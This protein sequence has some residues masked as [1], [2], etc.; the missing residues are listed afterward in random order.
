MSQ[1]LGIIEDLDS[2]DQAVVETLWNEQRLLALENLSQ[3]QETTA[4]ALTDYVLL[5]AVRLTG[6]AA[7]FL[8]FVN[9]N[10]T[11]LNFHSWFD[12]VYKEHRLVNKTSQSSQ[13][14]LE[15]LG[16][17]GEPVRQRRPIITNNCQAED[18]FISGLPEW[19]I[20]QKR[21]LGVPLFSKGRVVAVVG[22]ANKAVDYASQDVHFLSLLMESMWRLIEKKQ[23]EAQLRQAHKL[24]SIG[25]L[26]SGIAHD[27][28]NILSC[29][30][31]YS[32]LA[33]QKA[34][35]NPELMDYLKEICDASS[36]AS[37]LVK[38]ILSFSRRQDQEYKTVD[39]KE[40]VSESLKLL[41]A[42]IPST[43]EIRPHLSNIE[44]QLMGDGSQL[45][46]IVINLCTNAAY[47]MREK[48]GMLDV[49]LEL[50]APDA[51]ILSKHEFLRQ[52]LC[53]KLV[54]QDTG[55]GISS[56]DLPH[57][58]EPFFTTKPKG[59]GTGLGLSMVQTIIERHHG[60]ITV[61]S[62]LNRGT[63]FCLYFPRLNFESPAALSQPVFK[64]SISNWRI[65][66]VDD[67]TP[68]IK[69]VEKMLEHMKH[70]AIVFSTG[71]DALEFLQQDPNAV[72]LLLTDHTMPKM[73]GLELAT[74]ARKLRPDLPVILMTGYGA[75]IHEEHR[76]LEGIHYVL[77][78]PFTVRSLTDA[79]QICKTVVSQAQGKTMETRL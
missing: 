60:C 67:E 70:R 16:L 7:G 33:I 55:S 51:S 29:I 42:S 37:D 47:A 5:E 52:G 28:N 17:W 45:Q 20:L 49:S 12:P 24:E 40:V 58:F 76:H 46:Q 36:R 14:L 21:H 56:E 18:Q 78:K 66:V 30:T 74:A 35:E 4:Q 71:V 34:S 63:R 13:Y 75:E 65:L 44:S 32:E 54:I 48:G 3:M 6:S 61:T 9:E 69:L 59:E 64:A 38:Q 11:I 72:D 68:L 77:S 15:K 10:E 50:A 8:A 53:L 73:T 39:L 57:I 23:L 22:I 26:A 27:F 25:T 2:C 43:I 79:L 31:G 41:R 62:Q 1:A 19:H